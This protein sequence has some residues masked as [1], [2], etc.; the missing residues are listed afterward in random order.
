MRLIAL[1]FAL[2]ATAC[3]TP[4]RSQTIGADAAASSPTS[5]DAPLDGHWR[6]IA[7]PY[8]AHYH[9]DPNHQRVY[10]LG[11][12]RQR[13]DGLVL[14]ASWFRNSFG[15]PSVYAYA[16][17][18]FLDFTEYPPLFA[19]LTGGLLYGYKPP[20]E[21][22]VPFNHHGYSPGVVASLG[23]QFTPRYS[24]QL[25]FLGT[26]ALMLQFSVDLVP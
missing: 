22:K 12:E 20:Y 11:L 7:S 13:A 8:T 19:Q 21:D 23:W 26:S 17:H 1:S 24:A 25:N 5:D 16:G 2:A 9:H 15:Q 4:T 3:P 6:V 10:A 18:R 14:G